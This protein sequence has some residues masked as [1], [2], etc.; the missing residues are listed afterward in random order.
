MIGNPCCFLKTR[1]SNDKRTPETGVSSA[2]LTQ[3]NNKDNLMPKSSYDTVN[4]HN[5]RIDL[6]QGCRK[7]KC[8]ILVL[9]SLDTLQFHISKKMKLTVGMRI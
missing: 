9:R 8:E 3:N 6:T 1:F 7:K 5:I 4:E 2:N